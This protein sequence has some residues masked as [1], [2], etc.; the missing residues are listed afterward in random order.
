METEA[1][2]SE[3]YAGSPIAPY[4]NPGGSPA[5]TEVSSTRNPGKVLHVRG[6]IYGQPPKTPASQ[7]GAPL[8]CVIGGGLRWCHFCKKTFLL[9]GFSPLLAKM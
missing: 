8:W 5:N 1:W 6:D 4:L 2:A 3:K 9:K 7:A